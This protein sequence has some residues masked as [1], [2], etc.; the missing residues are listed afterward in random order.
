MGSSLGRWR[1]PVPRGLQGPVQQDPEQGIGAEMIAEQWG[2]SRTD[3]DQFSL[4]SH[5]RPPPHRMPCFRDQ[6]VAIKRPGR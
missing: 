5:E 6:I 3:L 1:K 2:L 4:D